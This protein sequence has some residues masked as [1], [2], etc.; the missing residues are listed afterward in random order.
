MKAVYRI[1]NNQDRVTMKHFYHIRYDPDIDEYFCDMQHTPC[2]C[3]GC[4]EQ[5]PKPWWTN[6]DKTLKPRYVTKAETGK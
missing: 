5:L 3:N 2:A 6:L 1:L 4:D